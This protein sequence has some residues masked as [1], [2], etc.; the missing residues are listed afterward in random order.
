MAEKYIWV[1]SR[2]PSDRNETKVNIATVIHTAY[3]LVSPERSEVAVGELNAGCEREM[4]LRRNRQPQD[5]HE[6]A[7]GGRVGP[8]SGVS[9]F[10][11]Y[12]SLISF[13]K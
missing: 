3:A 12:D 2:V 1:G 6:I 4:H 10:F 13:G 9:A 7:K 11:V 5:G 8:R